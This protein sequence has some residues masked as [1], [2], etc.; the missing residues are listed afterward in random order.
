MLHITD[1]AEDV[2]SWVL[3]WMTQN[4]HFKA[5]ASELLHA[6]PV[7]PPL[8]GARLIYH[9]PELSD[10]Y[11]QVLMKPLKPAQAPR[12]KFLVKEFLYVPRTIYRILTKTLSPIKGHDSNE[13]EVVGIMKNPLFNTIHGVPLNY[14]DFFMRTLE[15]AALSPFELKPYA[16]WI[17]RFLRPRSSINY[18]ADFQNHLSYL[19]PIEVFKRLI[20][21]SNEKGKFATIDEG[22]F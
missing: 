11:M 7:S 13:E 12:T 21:S 14:H 6:L 9:E 15:N 18:K 17:M 8:E 10:H 19:P 1:N 20:S 2:N 3:D 5:P 4:T 16:P 22:I